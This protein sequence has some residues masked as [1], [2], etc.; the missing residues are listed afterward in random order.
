M[1]GE[2]NVGYGEKEGTRLVYD[3]SGFL[4]T[5]IRSFRP[6]ARIGDPVNAY[7]IIYDEFWNVINILY[8]N[9]PIFV[10]NL[11]IRVPEQPT[12]TG[13]NNTQVTGTCTGSIVK[14]G[15]IITIMDLSN[16]RK[17]LGTG[18]VLANAFAVAIDLSQYQVGSIIALSAVVENS[19]VK[20]H[21]TSEDSEVLNYTKI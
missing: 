19:L 12:I 5:Q 8:V 10:N 21:G 14:D 9:G 2:K 7:N 20:F 18:T 17:I 13:A 3:P 15:D 4:L 6:N 1:S 16:N 11:D